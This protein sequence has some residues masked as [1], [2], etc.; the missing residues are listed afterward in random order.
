MCT[1]FRLFAGV[2]VLSAPILAQMG[3]PPSSAHSPVAA[4][5]A[6]DPSGTDH[7][8][9]I[10]V[11]VTDK[12][13]TSVPGLQEQD[14][15]LLDDKQPRTIV[16]FRATEGT[17][18]ATDPA[19]QVIF[20]IDAV[21]TGAQTVMY[22]RTQLSKF[23]RQDDGR[24]SAPTSL[25][26]LSEKSAEVQ[27]TPT[28]DGKALADSLDSNQPGLRTL[29]RSTGAY[30]AE[31]RRTM[32]LR[33]LD[34]LARYEGTQ[35]G[36]KL[37]IWL[38][39]GWPILSWPDGVVS[40]KNEQGLFRSIV[41]LSQE[42]RESRITLY[43]VDPLGVNGA[44]SKFYYESFL[45]GVPSYYQAQEGNIALQVLAAQSG[46]LVLN[47]GNDLVK[48]ITSCLEDTKAFYTLSFDSP[49]ADHPN[50]LHDLEVKIDKPGLK[51]RT[52]TGYYAERYATSQSPTAKPDE[53]EVPPV[54]PTEES[55]PIPFKAP[56]L[57]IPNFASCPFTDLQQIV[58]ELAGLK[59]STEPTGLPTLLN[60]IGAK[61]LEIVGRTP[62]LISHET[63][64]SKYG[65][66]SARQHFSYLVLPH[67]HP[68]GNIAFD[69]FR[70][71]LASG[72]KFQTADIERAL[73]SRPP[74]GD[75]SSVQVP[76]LVERLP[77]PG[78]PP[79]AQGFANMWIYLDPLNQQESS[80]RY[81]GQQKMSG[82]DTLVL[83]FSQKPESVRAP[84]IF[85]FEDK[86][87]PIFM[88]GVAWVD[89]SDFKIIRLRTDLL[90]PVEALDVR[91]LTANIEF[92]QTVIPE[93]KLPLWLPR[94]VSVTW[95]LS[96]QIIREKHH[97][98]DYRL[99][100]AHSRI[101]PNR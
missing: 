41:T 29:G 91:Q 21:N 9:W 19:L 71:N 16:S 58:P 31:E 13:G 87:L 47:S 51:A 60:E 82:H 65:A 81:L 17:S 74:A 76:T 55:P 56:E 96:G 2:L 30:G 61:I 73:V 101:L 36:R 77:A 40:E 25:V 35:P 59:P 18:R 70:V 53:I 45:K 92:A 68:G 44:G 32:S 97:Y 42:L 66:I 6:A 12:S 27:P 38:S 46:G 3:T 98:S 79:L 1:L 33:T 78:G 8:V 69:E 100:R 7:R 86:T 90:F 15:T 89:A 67:L 20:V 43:S 5:P 54:P 23:L 24:L 26:I 34:G 37:V 28:R 63:V 14:F 99:F 80:F 4:P 57:K 64:A 11:A 50:E 94:Q 10:D 95:N 49:P 84:A 39:P 52:R 93:L 83:A 72:K 88:Q 85:H 48:E 75:T 22:G 62:N